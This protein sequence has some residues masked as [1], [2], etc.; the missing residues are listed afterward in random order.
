[1]DIAEGVVFFHPALINIIGDPP[2]APFP[3]GYNVFRPAELGADFASQTI[4]AREEDIAANA[5]A[6]ECFIR[7]SIRGWH[8][9]FDD[10]ELAVEATMSFVPPESPITAD[11]QAAALPDVLAITGEDGHDPTLLEPDEESYQSTLD[12]LVE[13]GAIDEAEVP[14][15]ADTFDRTFWDA[16][17]ATE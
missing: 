8:A 7:A 4:A 2:F 6:I 12:Q 16:A 10:P 17:T 1:M 15:V 14:A 11:H 13:V 3:D 9:A 5:P